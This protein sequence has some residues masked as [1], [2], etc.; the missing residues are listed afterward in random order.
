VSEASDNQL[1]RGVTTAYGGHICAAG[2]FVLHSQNILRPDNHSLRI[3]IELH[4]NFLSPAFAST[5]PAIN[6]EALATL[7][8]AID[9]EGD[10]AATISTRG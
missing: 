8:D 4:H 5:F 3:N 9:R 6:H 2:R 10:N 7:M 1:G